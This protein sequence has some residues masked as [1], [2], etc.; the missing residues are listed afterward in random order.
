MQ[1]YWADTKNA[2]ELKAYL[3]NVI[4]QENRIQSSTNPMY[5]LMAELTPATIDIIFQIN[6]LRKLAN[7]VNRKITEWVR[8]DWHNYDINIIA[9]DYFLG[10]NLVNL[11]IYINNNRLI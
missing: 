6:K 3:G 2:A 8:D 9:T 1:Q 7:D 11:A 10:N 5:A 4:K